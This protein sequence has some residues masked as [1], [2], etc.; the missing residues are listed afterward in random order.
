MSLKIGFIGGGFVA[1]FHVKSFQS[2][3]GAEIVAVY[4][5]SGRGARRTA[6]LAEALDVGEAKVYTDLYDFLR[7]P[8]LE[9]VWVLSPNY[10]RLEIAKAI[11]EEVTQ[12]KSTLKAVAFEK[13]LAR[14]LEEAKRIVELIND[15]GLLHG[16]LENQVFSPA[17][18][19]GKEIIWRRGATI[20]G[21]PYLARASEEHGGPH[22]SWFWHPYYSGGGVLLDMGC[23]SIEACR[24]LLYDP[25]KGKGSLKPV[26]VEAYTATLKWSRP[27]YVEKLREATKGFVD[28]SEVPAEDYARTIVVFEDEEGRGVVA[29]S[30]NAWSFV[31]P[32]L[33]LTFEVFG[34]EYYMQVNTLQ[35][36]LFVFFSREVRGAAGED[37]IEKQSAEQGLMPAIPDEPF[38]YGYVWENRHMVSAFAS[39][40]SP[41]E[42]L[43]DALL[44]M[45]L[46]MAAYKSAEEKRVV[47]LPDP[48]L[49]DYKPKP[50]RE[51]A[52]KISFK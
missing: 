11:H 2:V 38:T 31:G 50:F 15:A 41:E 9:A 12:G 4:S 45:E 16:Y 29:E 43:R 3:R 52:E 26:E 22:S 40:R 17:I 34:P 18:V 46:L 21:R 8:G 20:S 6:E 47:K 14:N 49:K 30:A 39:G 48:A 5:P 35:P 44:V 37:L 51:A 42:N 36:E 10:T 32:G 28:Y 19:R 24:Y 33:R 7:H 13:P 23:H 1:E 27:A 25:A